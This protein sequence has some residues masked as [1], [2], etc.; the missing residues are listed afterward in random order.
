MIEAD[1]KGLQNVWRRSSNDY[2]IDDDNLLLIVFSENLQAVLKPRLCATLGSYYL[3]ILLMTF[4]KVKFF[5]MSS[6]I[7][8]IFAFS[9]D[10]EENNGVVQV[11]KFNTLIY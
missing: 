3:L 4:S 6:V 7:Q 8:R 9:L 11:C 2:D 5:L 1:T 10:S